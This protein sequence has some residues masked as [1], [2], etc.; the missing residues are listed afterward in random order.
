[1]HAEDV[2]GLGSLVAHPQ[3]YSTPAG[4]AL[5]VLTPR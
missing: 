1:M 2:T 5:L 3:V 4:R